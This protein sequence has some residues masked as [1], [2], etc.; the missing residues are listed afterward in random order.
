MGYFVFHCVKFENS[1]SYIVY[2]TVYTTNMYNLILKCYT[3]EN[4]FDSFRYN[5]NDLIP[6]SFTA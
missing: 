6:S 4:N 5:C 3:I 2:Y 1:S